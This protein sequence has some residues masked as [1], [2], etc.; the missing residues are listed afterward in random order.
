MAEQKQL[1]FERS[2]STNL[3][4]SEI[5]ELDRWADMNFSDRSKLCKAILRH[6]LKK[7]KEAGGL[8]QAPSDVIRRLRLDPA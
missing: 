3:Y 5:L 4:N 7:V 2:V 8:N 1:D 6:V